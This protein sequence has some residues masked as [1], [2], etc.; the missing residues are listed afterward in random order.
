MN[1]NVLFAFLFISIAWTSFGQSTV[2]NSPL[3]GCTIGQDTILYQSDFQNDDG[4][5]KPILN[6]TQVP[7]NGDFEWAIPV[8]VTPGGLNNATFGTEFCDGQGN[9]GYPNSFPWPPP[10]G[11]TKIWLT[12]RDGCY[13]IQSQGADT[14]RIARSFNMSNLAAPVQLTVQNWWTGTGADNASIR[15]NNNNLWTAN[16]NGIWSDRTYTLT[17]VA[18]QRNIRVEL[19]MFNGGSWNERGHLISNVGIRGCKATGS[20]S[21][22]AVPTLSQWGM[23]YLGLF[24]II[25]SMVF[26]GR[27][28]M[29]TAS[30]AKTKITL[31]SFPRPRLE[32][33]LPY[34][35]FSLFAI[36]LFL[37]IWKYYISALTAL[38]YTMGAFAIPLLAY[39]LYLGT[40]IG[41]EKQ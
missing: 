38:D 35:G 23:I 11:V 33:S 3:P 8:L 20:S 27:K 19:I 16:G 25:I 6:A 37:A 36:V 32:E 24:L 13:R 22:P 15:A 7:S 29:V 10:N 17:N 40:L 34:L 5:W 21:G 18:G 14:T 9:G 39:A 41:N 12:N 28:E 2:F 1:K 26:I 4:G 30:K 31:F